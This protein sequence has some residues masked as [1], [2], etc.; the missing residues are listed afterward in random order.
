MPYQTRNK[1]LTPNGNTISDSDKLSHAQHADY[2]VVSR[3]SMSERNVD[4][5]IFD[6]LPI[7]AQTISELELAIEKMKEQIERVSRERE[8]RLLS[9]YSSS[10]FERPNDFSTSKMV[11]STSNEAH[12]AEKPLKD[13]VKIEKDDRGIFAADITYSSLPMVSSPLF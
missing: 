7:P 8:E 6:D 13:V 10:E 4:E 5:A 1:P 11:K 12:D 9:E 2:G 3:Y